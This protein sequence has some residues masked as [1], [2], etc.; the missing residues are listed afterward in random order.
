MKISN[1][2]EINNALQ[3]ASFSVMGCT[4]PKNLDEN[5]RET[6]ELVFNRIYLNPRDEE[7]IKVSLVMEGNASDDK[8]LLT[9]E[10]I[11]ILENIINYVTRDEI[12]S[13]IGDVLWV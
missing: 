8:L 7:F 9:S 12:I 4:L 1:W 2:E 5:I 6:L 10:Q 11:S 13:R 3:S